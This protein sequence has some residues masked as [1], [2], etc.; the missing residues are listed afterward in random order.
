MSPNLW[1]RAQKFFLPNEIEQL[2]EQGRLESAVWVR[3]DTY[4]C[5]VSP[6]LLRRLRTEISSAGQF[7]DATHGIGYFAREE[8]RFGSHPAHDDYSDEGRP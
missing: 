5:P 8:G 2:V 1:L 7:D 4:I 6:S 3:E